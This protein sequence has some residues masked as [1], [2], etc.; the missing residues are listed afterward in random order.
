M[1]EVKASDNDRYLA[2][3][4]FT[5][6]ST[7]KD[8]FFGDTQLSATP[9]GGNATTYYN[10]RITQTKDLLAAIAAHNKDKL[11]VYMV[12]DFNSSKW[13]NPANAPYDLMT[14]AGYVDP[15]GNTYRSTKTA[16]GATVVTRIATNISSFNSFNRKAPITTYVNGSY[17]DYIWTSKG[18]QV[19][20]WQTVVDIDAA[21]NFVGIIPSDH[22]MIRATTYLP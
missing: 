1:T 17:L 16:T 8:F 2:W 14:A 5:Q 11:P 18:V 9:S 19:P 20:E 12:G 10:G 6:K 13:A 3:A 22:N 7:G 21:G 4:V 15:L